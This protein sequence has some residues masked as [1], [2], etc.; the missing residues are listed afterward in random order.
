MRVVRNSMRRPR[1]SAAFLVIAFLL[2]GCGGASFTN[3]GSSPKPAD[4]T[5]KSTPSSSATSSPASPKP[6]II[7]HPFSRLLQYINSRGGE[8]T[9]ALYDARTNRTWVVNPQ[10][11]EDTASIVKVQIMGALLHQ[12]HGRLP[13]GNEANLMQLMIEQS[14]NDAATSLLAEAG[15]PA[16]VSKFDI[17]A[18]LT[19]TTPHSAALIPGTPWPGWGLTT[20][21]A[22]DQVRLVK[23]FVFPNRVL[24]GAARQY[25]LRL[26]E[27]VEAD[28][29]W[30]ITGGVPTAGTTIAVKN[31]WLPLQGESDWQ[32][33]SIG[34][35]NGHG[36][37]YVLA[38]LTN[39]NADEAYGI[40]TIQTIAQ[41][42]FR[43][44]RPGS[45]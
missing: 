37:N 28:Q 7:Q 2:A 5:G 27:S 21:T 44:L 4:K 41:T 11:K 40:Q 33:D 29:A 9:A 18:G 38:V 1:S 20:T 43:E 32:I 26:M 10:F 45:D 35:I 16:G 24:T 39:G 19:D 12:L 25:G 42:I 6:H 22:L 14:D 3:T 17:T 13:T 30:G 23:T 8:V 36:R 31:G 15:G 34:W